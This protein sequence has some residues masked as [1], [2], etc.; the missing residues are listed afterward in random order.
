MQLNISVSVFRMR[1]FFRAKSWPGN[2]P[3]FKEGALKERIGL[4]AFLSSG[5]PLYCLYDFRGAH[6]SAAPNLLM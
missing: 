2:A 1:S 5:F 6:G 4:I 3:P